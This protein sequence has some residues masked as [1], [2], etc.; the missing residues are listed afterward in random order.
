M[1]ATFL[2]SFWL[3]L[4]ALKDVGRGLRVR[5]RALKVCKEKSV[6]MMFHI[7]SASFSLA[8]FED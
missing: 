5:A 3:L 4:L 7:F 8:F 2:A 6:I 1:A